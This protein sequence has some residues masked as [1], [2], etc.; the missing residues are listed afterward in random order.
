MLQAFLL[1][2]LGTFSI[3]RDPVSP[4]SNKNMLF[5]SSFHGNNDGLLASLLGLLRRER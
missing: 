4:Q 2:D 1:G 5:V 3:A